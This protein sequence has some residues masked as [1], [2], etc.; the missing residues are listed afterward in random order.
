QRSAD[1]DQ[2]ELSEGP[3]RGRRDRRAEACGQGEGNR[4]R[5]GADLLQR[6][7]REGTDGPRGLLQ[8][9]AR[10]EAADGRTP[11]NPVQHVLYE[12][13]GA[14][15]RGD[16]QRRIPRRNAQA[17]QAD[18][19]LASSNGRGGKWLSSTSTCLSSEAVRAVCVPPASRPVMA[20]ASCWPKSTGWA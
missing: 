14:E 13:L 16:R 10:P 19:K 9:A 5:H 1:V 6:V 4:R 2:P 15:L 11:G 17:G 8:V 18:L 20:P 12:R 7:H 3:Q